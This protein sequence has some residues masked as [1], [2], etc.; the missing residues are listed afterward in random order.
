MIDDES[1]FPV[2]FVT[3]SSRKSDHLKY[4][5]DECGLDELEVRLFQLPWP[6]QELQSE[7]MEFLLEE[8]I[9]RREL[10][11]IKDSF[12]I[13]EQTSVFFDAEKI[14]GPGQY[15]K[16]WWKSQDKEDL[17]IIVSR[18]PGVKV[19]SGLAMNIP[20]GR[21]LTF[22]NTVKGTMKLDGDILE[23]N[24]KYSWLSG[25]DFSEYFCPENSR[26]V[27]T[28]MELSEF[29]RYDFRRPNFE[30][31]AERLKD[32]SSIIRSEIIIE[33]LQHIAEENVPKEELENTG[34]MK[35]PEEPENGQSTL[36]DDYGT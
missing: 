3:T 6:Y 35:N 29:N 12:F 32:Y 20:G 30:K 2:F 34:Y 14:E 7:A 26:K 9:S 15:F 13:I 11:E 28:E 1:L 23:E 5:A 4:L 8:A 21:H 10:S 22:T 16:K 24:K 33:N 27:Y 31:I 25:G 19:E 18:N 36:T 17:E